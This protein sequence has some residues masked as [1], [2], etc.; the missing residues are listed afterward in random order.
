MLHLLLGSLLPAIIEYS[1]LYCAKTT[2]LSLG[3]VALIFTLWTSSLDDSLKI[4]AIAILVYTYW[5]NIDLV[6]ALSTELY[7]GEA[8]LIARQNIL[9]KLHQHFTFKLSG[10]FPT[11]P[12][13]IVPNYVR[14][15]IE[16]TFLLTLPQHTRRPFVVLATEKFI[17][18]SGIEFSVD[19]IP[20][21]KGGDY[22]SVT[23]KVRDFLN[24]GFDVVCYS[25]APMFISGRNYGRIRTGMFTLA[26]EFDLEITPVYFQ[27]IQTLFG[28]IYKQDIH[29]VVGPRA[30]EGEGIRS[31]FTAMD[32][33]FTQDRDNFELQ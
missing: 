5:R 22:N 12:S 23:G 17:A 33:L 27:P 15:R 6:L 25:Q 13:I 16:N 30:F 2:S 9:F 24:R 11:A 20:V 10:A 19:V 28:A 31:F 26:R 21:G 18:N 1:E 29:V 7:L 32:S 3:I 14:D 4:A 8:G